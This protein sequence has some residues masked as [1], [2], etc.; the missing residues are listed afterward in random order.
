MRFM[1]QKEDEVPFPLEAGVVTSDVVGH[2]KDKR[3]MECMVLRGKMLSSCRPKPFSERLS[4]YLA[5]QCFTAS[6]AQS[7]DTA[8]PAS[9][10]VNMGKTIMLMKLYYQICL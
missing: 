10:K 2:T 5:R 7:W 6:L 8:I 9:F 3:M 1:S 4:S